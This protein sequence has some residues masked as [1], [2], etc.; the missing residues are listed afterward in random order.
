M[1]VRVLAGMTA[2]AALAVL[3]GCSGSAPS[4]EVGECIDIQ[5]EDGNTVSGFDSKECDEPHD[6]EVV[7]VF[8]LDGDSLP[9]NS[10]IMQRIEEECLPAIDEYI[11]GDFLTDPD[12]DMYFVTPS[13]DTWGSS[14]AVHCIAVSL[15][16]E[17]LTES[18]R[19]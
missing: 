15:D 16:G 18:V 2:V 14:Q 17:P 6:G 11:G 19:S 3:T 5:E 4:A 9:S 8:D 13:E 1:K 7:H 12:L 10:E